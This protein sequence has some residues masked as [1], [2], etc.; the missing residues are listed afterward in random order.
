MVIYQMAHEYQIPTVLKGA[1]TVLLRQITSLKLK[2]N[3]RGQT[4]N[5][6]AQFLS[7]AFEILNF[8]AT[9]NNKI[10]LDAAVGQISSLPM[11]LFTK[12]F[13]Y[14]DLAESI[15]I[16]ILMYRLQRCETNGYIDDNED[17]MSL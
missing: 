15:K 14:K 5:G 8:T 4:L 16:Q 17:K 3:L 12:H 7:R 6:H 1:E 2:Y 9:Y 11:H 13:S 10:L